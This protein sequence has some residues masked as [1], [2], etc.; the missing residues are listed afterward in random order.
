MFNDCWLKFFLEQGQELLPN[1][2]AHFLRVAVGGIF[3]PGLFSRAQKTP[4]L[5]P[6]NA[7]QGTDD[8]TGDGMNSAETR[9]AG[10]AEQVGKH[11]FRLIVGSVRHH[12]SP[13]S[14]RFRQ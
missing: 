9:E 1:P 14:S 8:R 4:K 13:A 5:S 11:G 7:Q 6:A 3:M 10:A 12:D 2:S